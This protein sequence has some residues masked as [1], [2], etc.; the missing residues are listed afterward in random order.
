MMGIEQVV[1]R[2]SRDGAILAET[3]GMKGPKCLETIELLEDLL[4]AQA[5]ASSFT[6]EYYEVP[7]STHDAI[8]VNDEL[9]QH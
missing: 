5:V 1:V 7:A 8:E 4:E 9:R 2:I 6:K 3:K